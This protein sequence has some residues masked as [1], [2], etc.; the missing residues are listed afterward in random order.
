[1]ALQQAARVL[2]F[3]FNF[4]VCEALEHLEVGSH[5]YQYSFSKDIRSGE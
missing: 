1:M 2:P 3:V 5:L 4:T